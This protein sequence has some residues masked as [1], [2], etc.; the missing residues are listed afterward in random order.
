MKLYKLP[1]VY[2]KH[3]DRINRTSGKDKM[4]KDPLA[5]IKKLEFAFDYFKNLHN[6]WNVLPEKETFLDNLGM[7]LVAARQLNKYHKQ[8][9]DHLGDNGFIIAE[10]VKL[11]TAQHMV[12]NMDLCC[13]SAFRADEEIQYILTERDRLVQII[14]VLQAYL[15]IRPYELMLEEHKKMC[16]V[17]KAIDISLKL[18]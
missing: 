13:N 10:S 1:L 4:N 16:A 18:K 3:I 9:L 15:Q 17:E 8:A 14:N 7:A 2:L 6:D 5:E 12:E 11:R